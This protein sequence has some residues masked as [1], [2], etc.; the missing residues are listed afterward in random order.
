MLNLLVAFWNVGLCPYFLATSYWVSQDGF[1]YIWLTVATLNG[2]VMNYCS[3]MVKCV[4][5]SPLFLD[6]VGMQH[7]MLEYNTCLQASCSLPFS[8]PH[9]STQQTAESVKM[10]IVQINLRYD[11]KT[12]YT[13]SLWKS[14]KV[15]VVFSPYSC[16]LSFLLL[17]KFRPFSF[18]LS[19]LRKYSCQRSYLGVFIDISLSVE[20]T[21]FFAGPFMSFCLVLCCPVLTVIILI[22]FICW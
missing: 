13:N 7:H 3:L 18:S 21:F 1:I 11:P 12:D 17:R 8:A 14:L 19:L 20:H 22:C 5:R 6:H 2:F 9:M 16:V 15:C 4:F 10:G